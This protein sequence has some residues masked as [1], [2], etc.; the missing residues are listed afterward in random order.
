MF[1]SKIHLMKYISTFRAGLAASAV[2]GIPRTKCTGPVYSDFPELS[3][4]RPTQSPAENNPALPHRIPDD[5][6]RAPG[7]ERL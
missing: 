6:R 7:I 2:T 5:L 4:V 3:P 1:F